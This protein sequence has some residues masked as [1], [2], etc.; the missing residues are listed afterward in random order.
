MSSETSDEWREAMLGEHCRIEIGGTPSRNK[1]EFWSDEK[2]GRPWVSIADLKAAQVDRT[3][4]FISDLGIANSN[5]KLVPRGTIMMSF[6]LTIGRTAIAGCD[7]YTNEAIAAFFP[8]SEIDTEFLFYALPYAAAGAEM[9][10]AVKGVTLNKEKLRCLMLRLPPVAEQRRIAKVLRSVDE[11]IH[12]GE[13]TA[14]Q[15]GATASTLIEAAFADGERTMLGD[16]CSLIY[17][18]PGFYGFEQRAAGVPVIRGEHLRA[19]RISTDWAD[20]YFVDPEFS[21][22]FPKTVLGLNDVIMSV[23]GT[24]G[25]AAVVEAAHVGSQISPNLIRLVANPQR[26][27][28]SLLFFAVQSAVAHM[29]RTIVNAQAL[30]AINA[31]D[32]KAVE[33]ALPP[34][35]DQPALFEELESAVRAAEAAMRSIEQVK[36][37]RTMLLSDLLSGRVRVPA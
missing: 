24:V 1:P 34:L 5:V 19:G 20:F 2:K 23:R 32:L 3:K 33:I 10:Q 13:L 8:D 6:K 18:Y 25:T 4:E 31:G 27:L 26:I 36:K 11:A 28:P 35:D 21:A 14:A 37:V 22:Q 15:C 7:L 29:R 16:I 17:R 9:D 30:P 12:A